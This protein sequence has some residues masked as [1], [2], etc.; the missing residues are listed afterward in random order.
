M[1]RDRTCTVHEATD[2][3]VSVNIKFGNEFELHNSAGLLGVKVVVAIGCCE[4]KPD[5]MEDVQA[6]LIPAAV[7][8][9]TED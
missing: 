1:D 8:P 4:Q 7:P 6:W 9:E 2:T 5:S 3:N